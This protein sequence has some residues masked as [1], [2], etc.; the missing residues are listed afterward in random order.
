MLY[1]KY[2]DLFKTKNPFDFDLDLKKKGDNTQTNK[3]S[4]Y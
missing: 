2:S 4:V 3:K 1:K